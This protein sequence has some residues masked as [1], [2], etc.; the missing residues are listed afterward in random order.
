MTN[1]KLFGLILLLEIAHTIINCISNHYERKALEDNI[2]DTIY[3]VRR[4]LSDDISDCRK[5][6]IYAI[7]KEDFINKNDLKNLSKS[8]DALYRNV[9]ENNMKMQDRFAKSTNH[10]DEKFNELKALLEPEKEPEPIM[11]SL[12]EVIETIS[13]MKKE[14]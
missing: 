1:E 8:V 10:Y 13:K 9:F 3:G 14:K 12:D 11:I 4:R 2:K 7:E 6:T 5:K